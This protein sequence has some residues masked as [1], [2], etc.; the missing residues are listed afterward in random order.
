VH[1]SS[2]RDDAKE[3]LSRYLAD[4]PRWQNEIEDAAEGEGHALRTIKRAKKECGIRSGKE[5]AAWFWYLPEHNGR[6]QTVSRQECQEG[7]RCPEEGWAVG[8]LVAVESTEGGQIHLPNDVGILGTVG[9][10][11][12]QERA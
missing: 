4:G 9:P 1:P 11:E 2:T 12:Q 7:E 8:G 6:A 3:F 5:G 10:V